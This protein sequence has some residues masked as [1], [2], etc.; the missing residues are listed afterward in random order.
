MCKF[1]MKRTTKKMHQRGIVTLQN[2]LP[3]GYLLLFSNL[4][5]IRLEV[6]LKVDANVGK[7][8]IQCERKDHLL[9]KQKR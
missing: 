5:P 3:N 2:K 4:D 8:F 1:G 6:L 7:E 9:K